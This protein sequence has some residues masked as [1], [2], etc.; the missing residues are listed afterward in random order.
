ML[1]LAL[2]WTGLLRA[3]EAP[4]LA[5]AAMGVPNGCFVE[6]VALLDNLAAAAGASSWARLLQWGA[7]EEDEVVAGH[8]VAVV[9]SRGRLW[10]WDVNFG[11][12][13]LTLPPERRDDVAAVAA[14]LTARYPAISPRSPVYRYDFPQAAE[15]AARPAVTAA[16]SPAK[17]VAARLARHRPVNLV[18]FTYTENGVPKQGAAVVFLFH[19]RYCIYAPEK[20]TVPFLRGTGS[21]QMIPRIT[22]SLRRMFSGGVTDVRSVAW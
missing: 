17:L 14:P 13:A 8:A 15:T 4:P 22:A 20:G 6:T 9:E 1:V 18:E 16:G 11:W 2:G 19:G 5:H 3:A 10:C 12:S 21:V 7:T